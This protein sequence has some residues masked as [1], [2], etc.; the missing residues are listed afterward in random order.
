M[1]DLSRDFWI[2]E[3]GTGQQVAELHD[4]YMI[5]I[6]TTTITIIIIL[7]FNCNWVSSCGSGYFT[8]LN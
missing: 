3:T 4:R 8:K 1:V 2:R 5:I 7:I 6:I